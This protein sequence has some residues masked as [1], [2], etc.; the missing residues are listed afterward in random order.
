MALNVKDKLEEVANYINRDPEVTHNYLRLHKDYNVWFTI[1]RKSID[2]IIRFVEDLS[3]K[4]KIER[5][6]ILPSKRVLKLSV[7]YDLFLGLS[8]S[9]PFSYVPENVPNV[10]DLGIP[11]NLPKDLRSLSIEE[12]PYLNVAR[13]YG[14]SEEEVVHYI[15]IMLKRGVLLD[16]GASLD[17]HAIGFNEN[18]MMILTSKLNLKNLCKCLA[19]IPYT[20]HVV[21][22]EILSSEDTSKEVCYGVVHAVK[23]DLIE[24]AIYDIKDVCKPDDL[25]IVYS[26]KNLKPVVR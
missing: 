8:K 13:K 12:R 18:A 26:I 1:R 17:G 10:E 14:I 9:G 21:L 11:S 22:R 15:N 24:E 2:Q 19:T 6:L 5:W 16:P 25:E 4:F 23:K 7:K 3:K 20:T